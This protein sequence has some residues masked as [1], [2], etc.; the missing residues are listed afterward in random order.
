MFLQA[1]S[2]RHFWHWQMTFDSYRFYVGLTARGDAHEEPIWG[3]HNSGRWSFNPTTLKTLLRFADLF[4][5]E[6]V[7]LWVPCLKYWSSAGL[8]LGKPQS[9]V[10]HALLYESAIMHS[11]CADVL[12]RNCKQILGSL[13]GLERFFPEI[14]QRAAWLQWPLHCCQ[15]CQVCERSG[16]SSG[17]VMAGAGRMDLSEGAYWLKAENLKL[18]VI[19]DVLIEENIS[20][21][22]SLHI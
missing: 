1:H 19:A 12:I 6:T 21:T 17:A 13:K 4:R 14:T 15:R 2:L 20:S 3:Q 5:L 9:N 10:S 7:C 22:S 11:E 16:I 8:E 18:E